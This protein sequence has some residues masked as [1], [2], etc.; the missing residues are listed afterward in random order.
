MVVVAGMSGG[1]ALFGPRLHETAATARAAT[2]SELRTLKF[3][4]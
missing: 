4:Y 1:G 2:I 3:Y